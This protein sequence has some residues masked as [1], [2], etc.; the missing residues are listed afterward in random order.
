MIMCTQLQ[1]SS[2][3]I[4]DLYCT[5][6]PACTDVNKVLSLNPCKDLFR[7]GR[8]WLTQRH[9]AVTGNSSLGVSEISLC[10]RK[11]DIWYPIFT[12][13][14]VCAVKAID[15]YS[16]PRECLKLTAMSYVSISNLGRFA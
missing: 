10:W 9:V 16:G 1:L 14:P 11:A 5:R 8:T 2:D 12:G 6:D 13:Q 7:L 15:H 4:E 3:F